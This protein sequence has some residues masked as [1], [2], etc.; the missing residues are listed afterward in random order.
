MYETGAAF[1]KFLKGVRAE[2][3]NVWLEGRDMYKPFIMGD[4][5]LFKRETTDAYKITETGIAGAGYLPKV[6]MDG[7]EAPLVNRAIGFDETWIQEMYRQGITVTYKNH[8]FNG[9]KSQLDQFRALTTASRK[10]QDKV[11]FDIFVNGFDTLLAT[12]K[13]LIS[14]AQ[15][16]YPGSTVSGTQSNAIVNVGDSNKSYALSETSLNL[17]ITRL[18]TMKGSDGTAITS[19]ATNVALVVPPALWQTARVLA[20]SDLKPGSPNN[21]INVFDG[22]IKVVVSPY[23]STAISGKTYGDTQWFLVD[24]D[25]ADLRVYVADDSVKTEAPDEKTLSYSC[26]VHSTLAA[27]AST[28]QGV[29]GSKGDNQAYS[30]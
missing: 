11:A 3:A 13:P 9:Y 21:D 30:G 19:S 6:D 15:P 7:E 23:L 26:Y 8:R 4:T 17:G 16:Y 10:T 20:E 12:G 22:I 29:V 1:Q 18:M 2:F 25:V 14:I 5:K 28:W 24:M 27:K